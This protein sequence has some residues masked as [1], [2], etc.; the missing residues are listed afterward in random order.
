MTDT[1]I[2]NAQRAGKRWHA[3]DIASGLHN[4]LPTCP[5]YQREQRK[6]PLGHDMPHGTWGE[7]I[8]DATPRGPMKPRPHSMD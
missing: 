2:T 7:P 5:L 6:C 3:E 4:C 1:N 8:L